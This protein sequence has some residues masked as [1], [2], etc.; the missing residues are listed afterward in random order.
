[1]YL[2]KNKKSLS[3]ESN[4]RSGEM[5]STAQLS[6]YRSWPYDDDDVDGRED[7]VAG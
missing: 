3:L 1:M 5:C 7:R 6:Q 4:T 2:G